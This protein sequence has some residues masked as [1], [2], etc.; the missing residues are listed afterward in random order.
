MG[1]KI[2][3]D[4]SNNQQIN[5]GDKVEIVDKSS[6]EE[7]VDQNKLYEN[8]VDINITKITPSTSQATQENNNT[9]V[10]TTGS[11]G[12]TSRVPVQGPS[13]D[14][15]GE[16]FLG[17]HEA[18]IQQATD[19]IN[20]RPQ[21]QI[22][23][24][25]GCRGR[26]K[27]VWIFADNEFEGES[28][29]ANVV[30]I[31]VNEAFSGED[32]CEWKN[33]VK[34]EFQAQIKNGTWKIT[35]RPM[36]QHIIESRLVLTNKYDE[37]GNITRRKARLVAKGYS[38]RPGLDFNETFAPVVRL[39]SVRLLVALAAKYS[40]KIHQ[41]D[42]ITAFLNGELEENL[43]IDIPDKLEEMLQEMAASEINN[44]NNSVDKKASIMLNEIKQGNKV[45]EVTK[46]LYGLK[47][48]G[49]Q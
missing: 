38:Q 41:L 33:A 2:V 17:F 6:K 29:E 28:E 37:H 46:A 20:S 3:K 31:N 42:V 43:Y 11:L 39:S 27:K 21:R 19:R 34:E 32:Q 49:R 16:D 5:D 9:V 8:F 13:A 23:L 48:A 26:P 4:S 35:D 1:N 40:L 44:K 18:E 24:R 22:S 15:D 30:E 7:N 47:Q 45:C 12:D 25:T 14:S 36:D 10:P